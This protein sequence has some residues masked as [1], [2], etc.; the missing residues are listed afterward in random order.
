MVQLNI[1]FSWKE[2]YESMEM[3]LTKIKYTKTRW[4]TCSCLKGYRSASRGSKVDLLNFRALFMQIEG[5]GLT[6]AG[7][8]SKSS[9]MCLFKASSSDK[10]EASSRHPHQIPE[11]VKVFNGGRRQPLVRSSVSTEV[12]FGNYKKVS[13]QIDG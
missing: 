3:L 4:A 2:T 8:S 1:P 7:E 11:I 12:R 13:L 6:F 9:G 5:G 10:E